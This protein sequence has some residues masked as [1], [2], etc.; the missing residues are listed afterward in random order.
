MA[1]RKVLIK[2]L[3]EKFENFSDQPHFNNLNEFVKTDLVYLTDWQNWKPTPEEV[4]KL[5]ELLTYDIHKLEGIIAKLSQGEK[6]SG[7]EFI[8]DDKTFA[9]VFF[10]TFFLPSDQKLKLA[11]LFWGFFVNAILDNNLNYSIF[12]GKFINPLIQFPFISFLYYGKQRNSYQRTLEKLEGF[13]DQLHFNN[14]CEFVRN[15]LKNL[16]GNLWQSRKPNQTLIKKIC[17]GESVQGFESIEDDKTFFVGFFRTLFLFL[18]SDKKFQLAKLFWRFFVNAISDNEVK[19]LK[20]KLTD[21]PKL[22]SYSDTDKFDDFLE[23]FKIK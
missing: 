14:L 18:I 15:D 1:N 12:R 8:L 23:K 20:S 13:S 21:P 6:V 17:Q 4:E 7:F 16:T 11:K 10:R 3:E 22:L 2:E 9:V 19:F 5:E